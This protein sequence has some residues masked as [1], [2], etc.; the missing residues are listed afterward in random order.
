MKIKEMVTDE[1]IAGKAYV[2]WKAWQ[3]AYAGLLPKDFLDRRSLEQCQKWARSYP[4]DILVA[5]V[6]GQ[7]VGFASYG[8]SG[9][10]DL[11]AAGELYALYLLEDYHG[12][13]I[14]FALMQAA[15]DRLAVYSTIVLWV[16]EGNQ[17]AIAFYEKV[18]FVLDGVTKLVQLGQE[19]TE[20][21]MVLKR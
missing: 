16:L 8:R 17:P 19:K 12:Q 13:G 7:V 6:E 21:R 11:G 18:G 5:V 14:G 9:S 20:Y 3:E 1:E 2:H 10:A 4:Q 15:L